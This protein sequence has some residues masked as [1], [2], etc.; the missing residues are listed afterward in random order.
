ME[1]KISLKT[2]MAFFEGILPFLGVKNQKR[3]LK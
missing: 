1:T 2:F 3:K